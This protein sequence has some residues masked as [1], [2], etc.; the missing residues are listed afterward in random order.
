MNSNLLTNFIPPKLVGL[1]DNKAAGGIVLIFSAALALI[2]A[3]ANFAWYSSVVS[4]PMTLPF[5]GLEKSFALWVNDGLMALFFLMVGL[6]LR[7]EMKHGAL[8]EKSKLWLPAAAA[9]GGLAIPALL[10]V[11]VNFGSPDALR[12]WAIPVATDIAFAIGI[13]SLLGSRV[14]I[15]LKV[16]LVSIAIFDDIASILIIAAFYTESISL[17]A[18]GVSG[19]L[20]ASMFFLKRSGNRNFFIY[21]IAG[22]LLWFAVLKSGVHAT[23]AGVALAFLLP[24]ELSDPRASLGKLEHLLHR[25]SAWIILPIFAFVNCGV[26]LLGTGMAELAT[27]VSIGIA[28]SLVLGKPIGILGGAWLLSRWKKGLLPPGISW[29]HLFGIGCLCGVGFTMSLFIASLAYSGGALAAT[30]EVAK[31]GIMAG[32]LVSGLGGFFILKRVLGETVRC[33]E[34]LNTA[35]AISMD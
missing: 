23:L 12:G 1:L 13:L 20:A 19:V 7:R 27:P 29:N 32:S 6:E 34:K 9:F 3:N 21:A 4:A 28:L 31:L 24:G 8:K 22:F 30:G 15:F 2:V 26:Y 10:F 18:L 33:P 25:M 35:T 14:P 17:T 16:L 5:V 11:A